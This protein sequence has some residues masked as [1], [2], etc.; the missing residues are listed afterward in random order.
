ML[1]LTLL[2]W[3]IFIALMA[4]IDPSR[5]DWL[6]FLFFY[7]SLFLAL[8]GSITLIG[9]FIRK[10]INKKTLNFYLVKTS[11][12]QSFLFSALI[13]ATLFM[14]AEN[15]FS[16]LNIVILIIILSIIEYLLINKKN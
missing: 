3:S 9:F 16:W 13:S 2:S 14:L 4:S 12:R 1:G 5:A 6:A 11:F 7:F 15:L 10:K 8:S